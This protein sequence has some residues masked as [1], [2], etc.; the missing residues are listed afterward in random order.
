MRA[1]ESARPALLTRSLVWE[2]NG[3]IITATE[4]RQLRKRK[5][6]VLAGPRSSVHLL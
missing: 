2:S 4:D 1:M 5:P 6:I 3:L